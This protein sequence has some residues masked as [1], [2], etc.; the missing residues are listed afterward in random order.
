M[1]GDEIRRS[2]RMAAGQLR[3]AA[4]ALVFALPM[5]RVFIESGPRFNASGLDSM[6]ITLAHAAADA[7][8][9]AWPLFA[10]WVGALGAFAAGSNTVSN[11]MFALF[12]FATAL[13]IGANPAIVV[14]VQAVGGA[15]GNMITVHNVVAASA[16][17][18]LVGQEG[19]LIRK[20][21]IPMAYYCVVAGRG[22][23]SPDVHGSSV[24]GGR[25]RRRQREF[26]KG[27]HHNRGSLRNVTSGEPPSEDESVNLRDE[28]PFPSSPSC[29]REPPSVVK[30]RP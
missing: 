23:S 17:V 20:T 15:A 10:P 11:L 3:G 24:N 5:V 9:G 1:S 30:W 22:G 21:V 28:P 12:Q 2:W 13:E 29:C 26:I 7:A 19:A 14:A 18:G 8:G 6:P 25:G 16:T 27:F 4:V